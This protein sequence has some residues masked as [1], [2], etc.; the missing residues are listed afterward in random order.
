[1]VD[2][3]WT[4][5][6]LNCSGT[7][8]TQFVYRY[9][10]I[11]NVMGISASQF[12]NQHKDKIDEMKRLLLDYIKGLRQASARNDA[13]RTSQSPADFIKINDNGYPILPDNLYF[14]NLRK[15]DLEEL[16]RTYLGWHYSK[17]SFI[18]KI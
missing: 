13:E 4:G 16:L 5:K 10:R 1:M 17:Q 2:W 8:E 14:D 6:K 15:T 12:V 7:A 9:E 11:A 3:L 18:I